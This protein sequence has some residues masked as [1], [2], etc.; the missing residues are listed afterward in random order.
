MQTSQDAS[1]YNNAKLLRN[2]FQ[3]SKREQDKLTMI[4]N[5]FVGRYGEFWNSQ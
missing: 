1:N 3:T 4:F 5:I 2:I